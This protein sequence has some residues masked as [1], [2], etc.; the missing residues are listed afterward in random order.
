MGDPRARER[1]AVRMRCVPAML[2][3]KNSSLSSPL[4]SDE[5]EDLVQDTLAAIWGKIGT[6]SGRAKL[7]TW[8]YQFCTLELRSALRGKRRNRMV[9]F[10][11]GVAEVNESVAA[12]EPT[13]ADH[14][15]V[16]ESLARLSE[17]ESEVVQLKHFSHLTLEETARRLGISTNTVKT[18]YYRALDRLRLWLAPLREREM[19]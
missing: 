5:I 17:V 2:K 11:E 16:Y 14:D 19:R 7:E 10:E 18:R 8:V 9:R 15:G 1:F 6:Y 13:S 12:P 4:R 3:A